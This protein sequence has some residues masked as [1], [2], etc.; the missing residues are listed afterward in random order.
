MRCQRYV[1]YR[2][3]DSDWEACEYCVADYTLQCASCDDK[4]WQGDLEGVD[5]A[6]FQQAVGVLLCEDCLVE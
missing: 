5:V 1:V 4:F 3:Y 2:H 6:W